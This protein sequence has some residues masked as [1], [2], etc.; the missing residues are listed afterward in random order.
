MTEILV[1]AG[2]LR[3]DSYNRRLA[4]CAIDWIR[5]HTP[6][7]CREVDLAQ[8]PMPLYDAD[9]ETSRGIPETVVQLAEVFARADGV[10]FACPEY[11]ASITPLLKNTIDWLSR[12]KRDDGSFVA[13][14]GKSAALLS[15]SPGGLGGMRGLVHVTQILSA[16]Q[17]LV[18]PQQLAVA[19]AHEAFDADGH[20]AEPVTRERLHAVLEKFLKLVTAIDHLS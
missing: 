4:R 3:R 11:N 2:S 18:L 13:F 12:V 16:M 20:L 1:L 15:A 19:R 5:T 6:A 14:A 17:V 10:I 7:T 9:L 8:Y